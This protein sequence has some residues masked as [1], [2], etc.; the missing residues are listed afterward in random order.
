MKILIPKK[1]QKLKMI[2]RVIKI[3]T[4]INEPTELSSIISSTDDHI[5]SN[6]SDFLSTPQYIPESQNIINKNEKNNNKNI[7]D[8]V[9][10]KSFESEKQS[11]ENY[12]NNRCAKST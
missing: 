7:K 6:S 9:S 4:L 8:F 1:E 12:N 5:I 2:Y 3:I 10:I 11:I